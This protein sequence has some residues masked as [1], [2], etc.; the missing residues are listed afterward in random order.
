MAAS[1]VASTERPVVT[2]TVYSDIACPWYVP[3]TCRRH[4][5]SACSPVSTRRVA[6][7][8]RRC[9]IGNINLKTALA[10]QTSNVEFKVG[11]C[12]AEPPWSRPCSQHFTLIRRLSVVAQVYYRPYVLHPEV[13]EEGVRKAPATFYG[14][15]VRAAGTDIHKAKDEP[16]PLS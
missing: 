7:P 13:P 1:T 11:R 16:A 15:R 4:G 12:R 2:I 3:R 10:R 14:Q 5:K 6:S 9:A 8:R